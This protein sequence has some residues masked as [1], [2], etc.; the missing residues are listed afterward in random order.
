VVG[1][2]DSDTWTMATTAEIRRWARDH[3]IAVGVR[4]RLAPNVLSAYEQAQASG[5]DAVAPGRRIVFAK[6]TWDWQ[7]R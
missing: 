3:G 6:A 7:R 5:D 2:L 1:G 4:G